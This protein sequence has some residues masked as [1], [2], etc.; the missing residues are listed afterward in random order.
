MN[1]LISLPYSIAAGF[2]CLG[3][4]RGTNDVEV[5]HFY[6]KLRGK[7]AVI[8]DALCRTDSSEQCGYH[9]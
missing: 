7:D 1:C 2:A 5:S 3:S 4:R 6:S 9:V 8:F